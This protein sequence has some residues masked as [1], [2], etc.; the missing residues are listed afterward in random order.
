[1]ANHGQYVDGRPHREL[2][3]QVQGPPV[4]RPGPEVFPGGGDDSP[5]AVDAIYRAVVDAASKGVHVTI[6]TTVS[7]TTQTG[8][9]PALGNANANG[10]LR[11]LQGAEAPS[12]GGRPQKPPDPGKGTPDVGATDPGDYF[13]SLSLGAPGAGPWDGEPHHSGGFDRRSGGGND[14]PA[15]PWGGEEFLECSTQVR[16]G[17]CSAEASREHH[18][19]GQGFPDDGSG[20]RAF[21]H[22]HHYAAAG[23]GPARYRERPEPDGAER[24]FV[25]RGGYGEALGP[26]RQE[27]TGDDQSPGSSTSLE[28]P[29]AT[30]RDYRACHYDGGAAASPSDT[31]SLSSEE[32]LRHPDSPSSERPHYRARS[33]R[34]GEL[35]WGPLKGFPPSWPSKLAGDQPAPYGHGAV[36]LREQAKV[37]PETLKTLT[38][39]LDAYDRAAKRNRKPGKLNNHLEAVI[40]EAMS[41]LDKISGTMPSRDRQARGPKAKR[42]KISR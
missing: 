19:A 7:G 17:P 33:Y 6:T 10:G 8:P 3:S 39:D 24:H 16:S 40:H 11:G 38:H 12:R 41:E 36:H 25:S 42:R 4:G 5:E 15:G 32:D 18:R 35:V 37:E 13:C 21:H 28:G 1:M 20:Y 9:S 14:A 30:G 23:R 2:P 29:L 26:A 34:M 31:K 22:H 27:L